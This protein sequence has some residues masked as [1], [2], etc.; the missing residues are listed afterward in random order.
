MHPCNTVMDLV[1]GRYCLEA[2]VLIDN[3][4]E[5][6]DGIIFCFEGVWPSEEPKGRNNKTLH[7]YC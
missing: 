6:C 2:G 3:V 7:E 4:P 1:S 5:P